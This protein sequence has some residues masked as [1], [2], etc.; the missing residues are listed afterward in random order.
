MIKLL[1]SFLFLLLCMTVSA[2]KKVVVMSYESRLPLR[3]VY[4]RVDGAKELLRTTYQGIAELPD[5][6]CQATFNNVDY[7]QAVLNFDEVKDSVWLLPKAHTLDEVVVI[8]KRNQLSAFFKAP[9]IKDPLLK[10]KGPSGV[11]ILGTI[12]N[13]FSWKKRKRLK[14]ALETI[15]NY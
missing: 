8:G 7:L 1:A 9:Q 15:K 6:F 13:L 12:G 5:T 11:D 10:P 2:Q 4:I 14:K 3:D